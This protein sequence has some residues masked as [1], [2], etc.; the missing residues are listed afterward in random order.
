MDKRN[1][2]QTRLR[3]RQLIEEARIARA[4]VQAQRPTPAGLDNAGPV[5]SPARA[6][7]NPVSTADPLLRPRAR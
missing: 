4:A 1:P 2:E 3:A 6:L 5:I 7:A